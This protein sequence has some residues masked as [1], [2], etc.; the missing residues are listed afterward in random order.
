[1]EDVERGEP[2]GGSSPLVGWVLGEV[3]VLIIVSKSEVGARF[4]CVS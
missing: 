1:V 2:L 3:A 4:P